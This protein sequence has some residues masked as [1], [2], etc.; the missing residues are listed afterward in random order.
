MKNKD[1]PETTNTESVNGGEPMLIDGCII[2]GTYTCEGELLC[3]S[4]LADALKAMRVKPLL[5]DREE[6]KT[7]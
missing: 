1:M 6:R 7:K 5:D 2:C 4:C 3:P